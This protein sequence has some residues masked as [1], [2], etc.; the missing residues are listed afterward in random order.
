MSPEKPPIL[1]LMPDQLRADTLGCA[2]HPVI[3]TPSVDRLASEG[4]RFANAHTASPI[5]MPSRASF[6]NALYPHN[7]S[8]WTNLGQMPPNQKTF[9]HHLQRAGYFTA[10]IGKSHYYVHGEFH[11][12]EKEPYMHA[13][14]LDY[15]H[16]TTGPWATVRTESYMTDRWRQLGLLETFRDDYGRRRSWARQGRTPVWPSPLPEDEFPDSYV[17][18]QAVGFVDKYREE[19]PLCLFVGFGGPHSPWDAPGRYATMYDPDHV[20]TS[21]P[22]NEPQ[23]WNPPVT[24]DHGEL[25]AMPGLSEKAI[26]CLRAN[27]YGK[28]S[29]IDYWCGQ[30]LAAFDRKGWLDDALIVF[31][32]DHGEMAGDHQRLSKSVFYD[33]SVRIPLILRWP[34]RIEPGTQSAALVSSIDVGPAL[35]EAVT[36]GEPDLGFGQSLW[37]ALESPTHQHRDALF[38]E[39]A[40]RGHKNTMVCTEQYKYAL[41]ETGNGYFLVDVRD[42]PDE[43][44]NLIGHPDYR[45]IETEMRDRVLRFLMETQL[46]LE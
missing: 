45:Q 30:I 16:E 11:M 27:Y 35:L 23:P 36:D 2:G 38:S 31:W 9:F 33:A 4:V 40:I 1:I 3:Q 13:R 26:R 44:K 18:R 19:K 29:L 42:D 24:T 20:P 17:G 46:V 22:A 15:V 14:G 6:I 39:I 10:H 12:R 32:S 34:R 7:H 25:H 21:L 5:C 28:V 41:D 37:R 8:M 43:R